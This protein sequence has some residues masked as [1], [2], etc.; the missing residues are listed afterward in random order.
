MEFKS[1]DQLTINDCC[2]HLSISRDL[3]KQAVVA[4]KGN[5]SLL[6][7]RV[8]DGQPLSG[9]KEKIAKRL[10]S[11][12]IE[13][14]RIF[15]SCQTGAITYEQY[16]SI[17]NDGLWRSEASKRIKEIKD[18]Q[19]EREYYRR[20]QH[21][22]EGLEKYLYKYPQG[23]FS[24]TV[25]KSLNDKK[26]NRVV[27]L[28]TICTVVFIAIFVLCYINY[29]SSSYIS[30]DSD[31]AFGKKGGTATCDISTDAI[32]KNVQAYVAEDWIKATVEGGSLVIKTSPNHEDS[33]NATVHLYAYTTLFGINLW[34]KE[35]NVSVKEESG[36]STFLTVS[37]SSC[38][39]DKYG[40][41]EFGCSVET[42]GMNLN[43]SSDADW[44]VLKKNV[45]EKGNNFNAKLTITAKTN[46]SGERTGVILVKSDKFEKRI[47]VKQNSGLASYFTVSPNSIVMAEEGTEEGYCYSVDVNT[48]GT[49]W[50]VSDAPD[51]LTAEAKIQNGKLHITLPENNGKIRTGTITVISNN[52]DSREISVKQWGD[53]TDFSASN[54]TVRFGTSSDYEY[55][56]ISNNSRKNLSVSDDENWLSAT[57]INSSR[58]KISCSQ[59]NSSPRSG[60]VTVTCGNEEV[61]ITIKQDG[62]AECSSCD[63]EGETRCNHC[64]NGYTACSNS[65]YMG[66]F[67]NLGQYGH[68]RNITLYSYDPFTGMQFPSGNRLDICPT[69]NGSFK[70]KCSYCGGDG[71]RTC[72]RCKGSGKIK[73]SY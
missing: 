37:N 39:F 71:K 1:I 23:I 6:Y 42:D 58:I 56:G 17:S 47:S 51:W 45:A 69:C 24:Q 27:K 64:S 62:W 53:P 40:T 31:V 43:I 4:T 8:F 12:L 18:Q 60:T 33:R 65:N 3:L 30:S 68:G 10:I 29:H 55:I 49:T 32:S 73:K 35:F 54:S 36:L 44:I 34:K 67:D 9:V 66:V 15:L 16:L 72:S 13:D 2:N 22:I 48:D 52:G 25:Q 63:G 20:N 19:E 50:S 41:G 5:T 57:V 70:V 21:S 38:S 7:E 26:R 59:N 61:S 14:R 28:I 11:L 46:E